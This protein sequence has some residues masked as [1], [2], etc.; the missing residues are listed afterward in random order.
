MGL[1]VHARIGGRKKGKGGVTLRYTDLYTPW[2]AASFL[3]E[4]AVFA[5]ARVAVHNG[6]N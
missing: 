3:M 4:D 2:I 5:S 1:L 6:D